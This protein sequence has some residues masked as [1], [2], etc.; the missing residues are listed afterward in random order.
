MLAATGAQAQRVEGDRAVARGLYAAEVPVH[1]QNEAEREA[2]CSRALAEVLAKL[3][4]DRGSAGKPG[5]GR[6]LRRAV[7]YVDGYDYR[8]DE[9]VSASGAPGFTTK[10]VVRF[11]EDDI[12]AL[13]AALGLPGWPAPRPK[14]VLWPAIDGGSRSAEHTSELQSQMRTLYSLFRMKK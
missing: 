9:G 3:S 13:A 7:D 6:E 12:D 4:G 14:P 1:S 8:Q 11:R 10:L 2:G 5:V